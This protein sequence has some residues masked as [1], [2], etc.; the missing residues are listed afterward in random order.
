LHRAVREMPREYEVWLRL[1]KYLNNQIEKDHCGIRSRTGSK[2]GFKNF[3]CAGTTIAGI[4]L[5]RSIPKGQF[6]L[7]CL[8]FENQ[9]H[10][11]SN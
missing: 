5:L 9:R 6:A 1:S 8:R 3:D 2:L 11:Q 7:G 10:P 4:E